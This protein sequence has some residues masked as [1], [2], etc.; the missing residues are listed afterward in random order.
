MAFEE[1]NLDS[2]TIVGIRKTP[3]KD[4]IVLASVH[5]K[6]QVIQNEISQS[7][8]LQLPGYKFNLYLNSGISELLTKI[9]TFDTF[10]DF[11]DSHEGIHTGNIRNKLF[12]DH[13]VDSFSRKLILGGSEI[14]K[15]FIRWTGKWV[16]YNKSLINKGEGEYAGLGKPQYFKNTK[17][18]VRRTGD[19]ILAALDTE[20]YYFSNNVFV[21]IPKKGTLMN[22]KYALALLNCNL[23][24]WYYRSVQPRKG[25]LF[26]ELKINVLSKLP[27][28]LITLDKQKPLIDFVDKILAITRTDDYLSNPAKQAQVKEYERQIDQLVYELYGLTEEEIAV[29]EGSYTKN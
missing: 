7:K 20:G 27:L 2:C 29:V 4:N 26:A 6:G 14:K 22:V 21:C 1:V 28:R 25:K 18:V 24:T 9:E 3:K 16:N 5:E 8:F 11:F 10:G 23:T 15:Y 12:T 13:R 19:F 17:I